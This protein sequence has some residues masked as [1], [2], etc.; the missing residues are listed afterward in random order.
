MGDSPCNALNTMMKIL[1]WILNLT[2]SQC[3]EI[4]V[5]VTWDLFD[6]LVKSLAAAFLTTCKRLR[7]ELLR[8][9]KRELQ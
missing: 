4:K 8:Q 7:D 1:K 9:V 5:G 2:G 3:K 6:D